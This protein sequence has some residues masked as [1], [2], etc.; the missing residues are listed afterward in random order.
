MSRIEKIDYCIHSH[1]YRCGHAIGKDEEYVRAA[2][3]AGIKI[4]GYSDHIFLEGV[5]QPTVRGHYDQMTDYLK[6]IKNMRVNMGRSIKIYSGFEAEYAP[7]LVD[8]YRKLLKS[9]EVDYLLLGQHF[10][11]H[12]DGTWTAYYSSDL[13]K[14]R[15]Y[16][17]DYKDDLIAGMKT[18]L[19]TYVAHPDLYMAGYP[20]FD[21]F[22]REIAIEIVLTAKAL[23]IPL[24]L[25]LGGIRN[26]GKRVYRDEYR[27][28]YPVTQFWEIVAAYQVPVV[29]GIDAHAPTDYNYQ[30][31]LDALNELVGHL[32]L[33]YV[34]IHKV[35][36][37]SIARTA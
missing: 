25:N 13:D 15:A 20:Q 19:F 22:A 9:K 32:D 11:M 2:H 33:N 5:D 31:D 35:L 26:G 16:V 14:L 4:F 23:N 1:T 7:H 28:R 36:K 29:I 24:E 21:S 30:A 18:G 27:Y 34:D 3:K 8:V 12:K 37:R 17:N 10:R 6:M